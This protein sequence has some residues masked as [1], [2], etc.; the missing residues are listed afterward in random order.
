MTWLYQFSFSAAYG[1]LSW[2][3]PAEIFNTATRSK[4]VAI[5]TITPSAYSTNTLIG[6]VSPI[7]LK[8][9]GWKYFILFIVANFTNAL[10][11]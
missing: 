8:D 10:L 9:V 6:Q 1:L 3:I 4:G 2:I 7:A 11:F 5:A